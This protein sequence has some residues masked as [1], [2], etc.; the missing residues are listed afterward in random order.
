MPLSLM[1]PL[2]Q[3]KKKKN[4]HYFHDLQRVNYVQVKLSDGLY[5]AGRHNFSVVSFEFG[6]S[7]GHRLL[8]KSGVSQFL[9]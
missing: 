1:L 3:L 2:L 9:D 7:S 4:P 8:A 5:K 6:A